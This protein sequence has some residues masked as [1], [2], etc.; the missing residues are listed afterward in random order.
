MG[1]RWTRRPLSERK[2]TASYTAFHPCAV[3]VYVIEKR[4]R[5][6][7]DGPEQVRCRSRI[8]RTVEMN[9]SSSFP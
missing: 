7:G 2:T 9:A 1:Q 5:D 6:D 8:I 4:S 3:E